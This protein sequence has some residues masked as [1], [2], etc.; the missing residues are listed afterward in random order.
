MSRHRAIL[1]KTAI[2]RILGIYILN[3][4]VDAVQINTL[5]IRQAQIFQ[6]QRHHPKILDARS[7][8]WSKLY[9][10][11]T[12]IL[13]DLYM[14]HLKWPDT[15]DLCTP[16]TNYIVFK[17]DDYHCKKIWNKTVVYVHLHSSNSEITGFNPTSHI[18]MYVCM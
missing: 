9:T 14:I 13:G 10:G 12:Q 6:T 7:M 8:T 17:S 18:N 2:L 4:A 1:R 5:Y 15:Q 11:G 3:L 16:A